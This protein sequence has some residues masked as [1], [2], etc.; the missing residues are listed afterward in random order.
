MADLFDRYGVHRPSMLR[1][2]VAGDTGAMPPDAEWQAQLWLKLRECIGIP[3]PAERLIEA[4]QRLRDGS[5]VA[6][7]S[8][9]SLSL[10]ADEPPA[11]YVDVLVALSVRL[12]VHLFLLHPSPS[13]WERV[14]ELDL[15]RHAAC[16]DETTL[17]SGRFTT[18]CSRR[19]AETAA[20]CNLVLI[21]A[22]APWE[23]HHRPSE[24]AP[25]SLLE[26][27]QI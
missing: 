12:D 20:R 26:R 2:W 15:L 4:C 18:R 24:S 16:E 19:G 9:S 22:G 27:I 17:Y 7:T 6:G 23:D 21:G 13:L 10:R 14:S 1:Q 25:T 8:G 5:P 3:S 11:S